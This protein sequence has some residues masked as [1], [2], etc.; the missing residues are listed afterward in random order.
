MLDFL[1]NK[2]IKWLSMPLHTCENCGKTTIKGN[3][4]RW[5]S[6]NCKAVKGELKFH[7]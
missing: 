2:Y 3:Y 4:K 1:Q 5:H 7:A 6:N